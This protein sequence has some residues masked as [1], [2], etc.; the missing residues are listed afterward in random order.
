[1][2]VCRGR[3]IRPYLVSGYVEIDSPEMD[4]VRHCGRA[5]ADSSAPRAGGRATRAT[6][7]LRPGWEANTTLLL[8]LEVRRGGPRC[9]IGRPRRLRSRRPGPRSSLGS[10]SPARRRRRALWRLANADETSRIHGRTY[11]SADPCETRRSWSPSAW[12]IC[13][14]RTVDRMLDCNDSRADLQGVLTRRAAPAAS[15]SSAPR[16]EPVPVGHA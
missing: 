9:R 7:L 12:R 2:F 16:P 14:T 15:S 13:T 3:L 4:G 5:R 6:S 1:M 11:G 10:G 8:R